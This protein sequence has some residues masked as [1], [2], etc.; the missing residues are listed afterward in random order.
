[1]NCLNCG[2]TIPDESEFCLHCGKVIKKNIITPRCN[3]CGKDIP[4]DSEFC[5]FCGEKVI[6]NTV[7]EKKASEKIL[8]CGTVRGDLDEYKPVFN[9]IDIFL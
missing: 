9:N 2:K 3:S 1:M 6:S 8:V 4:E 7:L 5:P